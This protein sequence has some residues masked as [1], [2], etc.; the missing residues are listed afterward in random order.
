MVIRFVKSN[1]EQ[2]IDGYN[3]CF[4]GPPV[5]HDNIHLIYTE[6]VRTGERV[7]T[8]ICPKCFEKAF[9]LNSNYRRG[10]IGFTHL[11][12]HIERWK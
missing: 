8:N 9:P 12:F 3:R 2:L 5:N 4:I 11:P 7:I 1:C 10:N 6:I